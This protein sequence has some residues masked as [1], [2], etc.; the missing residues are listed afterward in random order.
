MFNLKNWNALEKTKKT[1][2]PQKLNLPDLELLECI[3]ETKK[4]RDQKHQSTWL[5]PNGMY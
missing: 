3:T 5:R 2:Y 1:R 4:I